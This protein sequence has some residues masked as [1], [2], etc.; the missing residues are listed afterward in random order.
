[1]RLSENRQF[2]V[3]VG[4]AFALLAGV[5]AWK[6]HGKWAMVAAALAAAL[7]TLAV[8]AEGALSPIR[9]PWMKA[10]HAMSRVTTPIVLGVVYF[11]V[12]TP[13]GL[14]MRA[15]GHNPLKHRPVNG[16]MWKTR[17]PRR[18]GRRDMTRQF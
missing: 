11:F 9:A 16:S 3:T 14:I 18:G 13:I 6:D 5:L 17:E 15:G 4:G 7:A 2:A 10:A 12:I 8:V 1:L